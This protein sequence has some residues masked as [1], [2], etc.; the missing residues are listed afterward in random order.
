[1]ARSV[2]SRAGARAAPALAMAHHQT[3]GFIGRMPTNIEIKAYLRDPERTKLI[4]RQLSG[5][6]PKEIRQED[7]FFQIPE[8]R[9]KLRQFSEDAGELIFYRRDDIAGTKRSDYAI[10]STDKPKALLAVLAQALEAKVMVLKKRLVYLV[11]Q[12]RIHVDEVKG[13]GVFLELEVVLR[14]GQS[15]EEG[16]KIAKDLMRK[17]EVVETDLIEGSYADLQNQV[18]GA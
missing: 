2:T 8:G 15:S 1:M 14:D 12:T 3:L 4:A 16:H 5:A 13:L 17:L 18:H 7:T 6:D 11:D 9:L 10:V